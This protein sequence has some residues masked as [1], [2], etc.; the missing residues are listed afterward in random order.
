LAVSVNTSL[1]HGEA[2]RVLNL[3]SPQSGSI[4]NSGAFSCPSNHEVM[5]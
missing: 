3:T 4:V 1:S 2:H 5:I